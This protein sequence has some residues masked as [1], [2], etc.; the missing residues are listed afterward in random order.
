MG[1]GKRNKFE[2]AK[3]FKKSFASSSLKT[4]PIL[5]LLQNL[6]IYSMNRFTKIILF[7]LLIGQFA[8]CNLQSLNAQ[9]YKPGNNSGGLYRT[10]DEKLDKGWFLGVGATYMLP[11][12]RVTEYTQHTDSITNTTYSESYAAQ[13]KTTFSESFST[14]IGLFLEVG[15]FKMNE[16]RIINY[17]DY[18]I[19]YKWF[20]GGENFSQSSKV[21]DVEVA[22]ATAR[23]TF[24]DH[25]LSGNY[26]I[27]HRYDMTDK[28]FLV[29]GIGINLDYLLITSRNGGGVLPSKAQEFPTSLI[30]E[31]HY[32]FGIGFK[33]NK[34]LIIMPMIETPILALYPFNHIVSTHNYFNTRDRP[35]FIKIRFMFLKKGSTSCP[36]VFNP[37]GVDPMN[38]KEN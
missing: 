13:P 26:N 24:S 6:I 27:G 17:T 37:M 5:L 31:M 9:T 7:I 34:R 28:T 21:N 35:V 2:E 33:T 19:S 32:F 29:N 36:K 1:I 38:Q 23:G 16:K 25:A 30:G 20:R 3:L 12:N 4:T 18:G 14:Q 8:I 10:G 22:Y 15:K 11:Y